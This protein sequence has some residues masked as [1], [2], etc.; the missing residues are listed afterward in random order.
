MVGGEAYI[1]GWWVP[2][3]VQGGGIPSPT[4]KRVKKR[5]KTRVFG[6]LGREKEA[7]T[8]VFGRLG[9]KEAKTRE[10]LRTVTGG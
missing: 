5:L 6:R 4:V 10:S 1:P 3:M 2:S 7:K 8:R 9:E